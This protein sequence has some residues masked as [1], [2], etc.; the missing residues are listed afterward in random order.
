MLGINVCQKK[1]TSMKSTNFL[2]HM[3]YQN[4]LKKKTDNLN[5]PIS[6]KEMEFIVENLHTHKT[7]DLYR[8]TDKF[9]Q[10]G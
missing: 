4:T 9:Y 8:F 1:T 10:R 2:K 6:F 5:S 7:P 3:N